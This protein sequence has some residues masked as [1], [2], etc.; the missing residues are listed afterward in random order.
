[1]IWSVESPEH[2]GDSRRQAVTR[3]ESDRAVGGPQPIS[4]T[5]VYCFV[6][7]GE[8]K[9]TRLHSSHAN[10]ARMP[11]SAGK[12]KAC[13]AECFLRGALQSYGEQQLARAWGLLESGLLV[14][15]EHAEL[16]RLRGK[17][18][19]EVASPCLVH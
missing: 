8:R 19:R 10:E 17:V 9:S 1:M 2:G 14:D 18:K 12:K 16:R 3:G 4:R 15:G 6:Q 5:D 7:G 13:L 11:S